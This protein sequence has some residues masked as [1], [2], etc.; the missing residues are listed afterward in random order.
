MFE[1]NIVEFLVLKTDKISKITLS[2]YFTKYAITG[3]LILILET[4]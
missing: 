3:A 2:D 1:E 4:P